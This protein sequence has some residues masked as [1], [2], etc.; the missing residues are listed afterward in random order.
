M[1]IQRPRA[2]TAFTLIEL[3]VVVAI[4][5]ILASLLLPALQTARAKAKDGLCLA[6]MRQNGLAHSMYADDNDDYPVRY[7]VGSDPGIIVLRNQGYLPNFYPQIRI[8]LANGNTELT[9]VDGKVNGS[10]A[11]RA[12]NLRSTMVCPMTRI[13]ATYQVDDSNRPYYYESNFNRTI[14]ATSYAQNECTMRETNWGQSGVPNGYYR[15]NDM[16]AEA[17]SMMLSYDA[18]SAINWVNINVGLNPVITLRHQGHYNVLHY[19]LHVSPY[20]QGPNNGYNY[21]P[22]WPRRSP[23]VAG[24][25]VHPYNASKSHYRLN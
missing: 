13:R 9:G 16:V 6:N 10:W 1:P 21:Y 25:Q 22:F 3:L 18:V 8:T 4:I 19:D 17:D 11:K 23:V 7:Y 12:P 5:A 15:M 24:Q 2:A 14:T 20:R